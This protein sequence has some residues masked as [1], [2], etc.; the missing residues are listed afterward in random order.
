MPRLACAF[1]VVLFAITSVAASQIPDP[2]TVP[3]AVI[4]G[5]TE[6]PAGELCVFDASGST[7]AGYDWN[8]SGDRN[9]AGRWEI[10]DDGRRL[11]FASPELGKY[12]I[13]LSVAIG[14]Q[15]DLV[16][17]I[18]HN[19]KKPDP[20]DDDPDD[21]DPPLPPDNKWQIVIVYESST[22]GKLSP[23][24]QSI[25]KSLTFR[26]RLAAAGHIILEGGIF[27]KDGINRDG[28][29]PERI[30]PFYAAVRNTKLPV[31]CIAPVASGPVKVFPL[32]ADEDAVLKLLGGEKP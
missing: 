9:T 18:L 27:D 21:E 16:E 4:C 29:T 24:Q 2:P 14:G 32:P 1:A 10:V 15:S 13:S 25:I 12:K 20:D 30:A 8:V 26:Q 6:T 19:G 23:E 7:G 28:K 22:L 5:P 3:L 11:V 17:W 31:L